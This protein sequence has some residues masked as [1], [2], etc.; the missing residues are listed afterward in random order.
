MLRSLKPP[1]ARLGFM[2]SPDPVRA[3]FRRRSMEALNR[4]GNGARAK[5]LSRA[6]ELQPTLARGP[7]S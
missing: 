5:A 1:A 6:S 4:I 7:G 2:L 3:A